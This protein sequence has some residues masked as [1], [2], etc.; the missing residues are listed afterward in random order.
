MDINTVIRIVRLYL[1]YTNPLIFVARRFIR[2]AAALGLRAVNCLDIGA[3]TAPYRPDIKNG[4]G[5]TSYIASDIAPTDQCNVV[6]NACYLPFRDAVFDLVVSFEVI[7]AIP[8]PGQMLDEISRV[9][10]PEGLVLLTFPFMYGEVDFHD[11]HRWTM[12]GMEAD[13]SRYEFEI[14]LAQRRGGVCF[15]VAYFLN[16]AIHHVI[17]GLRR[18]WR[19]ERTPGS[20]LRSALLIL[21]TFPITL[22]SWIA[23][24]VDHMLPS[25]GCYVG[26]T[27]LARKC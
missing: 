3:G 27:I 11:Y 10:K 12:E 26:G 20:M 14:I 13:L 15:A 7:Q 16:W 17:P 24:F 4:L 9:L 5:V 23:L 8:M 6:A 19:G 21:L 25:H 22:L 2:N 1:Y 18:S